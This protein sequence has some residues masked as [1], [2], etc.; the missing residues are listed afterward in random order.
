MTFPALVPWSQAQTSYG[1][2]I[3]RIPGNLAVSQIMP[4]QPY[5]DI[6]E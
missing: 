2:I 4:E 5:R 3:A 1:Q 6:Y